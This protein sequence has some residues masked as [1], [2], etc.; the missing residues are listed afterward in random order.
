MRANCVG[1]EHKLHRQRWW[2][3]NCD[4]FFQHLHH[5]G[6]ASIRW[7]GQHVFSTGRVKYV[8]HPLKPPRCCL[9]A[10]VEFAA[11]PLGEILL[12]HVTLFRTEV[13]FFNSAAENLQQPVPSSLGPLA[14]GP[15]PAHPHPNKCTEAIESQISRRNHEHARIL[16]TRVS[17]I[18]T[19]SRSSWFRKLRASVDQLQRFSKFS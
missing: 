7:P 4:P 1:V 2:T 13:G 5:Q 18:E 12:L 19:S 11:R 16:V 9:P 10:L 8:A 14:F 17:E 6:H 15:P 3:R